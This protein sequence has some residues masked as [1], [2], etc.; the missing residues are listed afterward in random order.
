MEKLFEAI[1]NR[2]VE[3]VFKIEKEW[4]HGGVPQ[5]TGV[6]TIL[7]HDNDKLISIRDLEWNE[8]FAGVSKNIQEKILKSL[9]D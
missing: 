8:G 9:L 4:G 1:R 5:Y 7:D 6:C 3:L 2:N